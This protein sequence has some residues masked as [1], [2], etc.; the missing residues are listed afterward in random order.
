MYSTAPSRFPHQQLKNSS[1]LSRAACASLILALMP[2]NGAYANPTGGTVES[3]DII[4]NDPNGNQLVIDQNSQS[5]VI[6]WDSFDILADEWTI[7]N[8]PGASSVT[9]N[10]IMGGDA[11]QILGRLSANGIIMIVNP[12][13][14][15][16]GAGSQVDV[17][18]L[19]ATTANISTADFMAG[20]MNFN[21]AGNPNASI[22][23]QGTITA[24]QGG[25]VALVAPSVVNSGVIRANLGKVA[26]GA[27]QTFSV[28]LYGDN[29]VS[30]AIGQAATSAAAGVL[31]QG[32]LEG[33]Q[34]YLSAK[35]AGDVMTNVVNNTG[36]IEASGA[37][38]DG[39]AIVLNGGSNGNVNVAGTVSSSDGGSVSITGKNVT[40]GGSVAADG[41]VTLNASQN[42]TASGANVNSGQGDVVFNSVDVTLL[43]SMLHA[44]DELT[45]NNSGTFFSN[46]ANVLS[47]N[48]VVLNQKG[49]SIQNAINAINDDATGSSMLRLGAHT[50]N[51]QVTINNRHNFTLQGTL[52]EGGALLSVLKPANGRGSILSVLNSD[53]ITL[54]SLKIDGSSSNRPLAGVSI[55]NSSGVTLSGSN[56][57]AKGNGVEIDGSNGVF[58]E[59]N[60]ISSL[61]NG[62]ID[63]EYS[64]LREGSAG[65]A[66]ERSNAASSNIVIENNDISTG[67]AGISLRGSNST[68]NDNSIFAGTNGIVLQDA[69]S[70][71]NGNWIFSFDNGLDISGDSS[72]E[73]N[74]IEIYAGNNAVN[75]SGNSDVAVS[76]SILVGG[77][78]SVFADGFNSLTLN[79]N[80]IQGFFQGVFAING[81]DLNIQNNTIYADNGDGITGNAGSALIVN[82]LITAL[83]GAGVQLFDTYLAGIFGNTILADNGIMVFNSTGGGNE[84]GYSEVNG[85]GNIINASTTG[86]GLYGVNNAILEGN[87]IEGGEY[88][89]SVIDSSNV[90]VSGNSVTGADVTGVDVNGSS[91]VTVDYNVLDGNTVGVNVLN[92]NS[93]MLSLNQITGSLYGAMANNVGSLMTDGNVFMNNDTAF[94]ATNTANWFSNGDLFSDNINGVVLNNSSGAFIVN[95]TMLNNVTGFTLN[96]SMDA[97]VQGITVDGGDTAFVLN[98]NTSL[99]FYN[100]GDGTDYSQFS[101]LNT[102][103]T[104]QDGAGIGNPTD[105]SQQM[106][107]YVMAYDFTEEELAA[108][109]AKTHDGKDKIDAGYVFY[110]EFAG[111]ETPPPAN[112]DPTPPPSNA[113]VTPPVDNSVAGHIEHQGNGSNNTPKNPY[114][115]QGNGGS[116]QVVSLNLLSTP[117]LGE[118]SPS[119][120]GDEGGQNGSNGLAGAVG[121]SNSFLATGSVNCSFSQ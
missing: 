108:A 39:N 19:V 18:G 21:V 54:A 27:G 106:F 24:A 89:I 6:N 5:G 51:E 98:G 111:E 88:G 9:L 37:Y 8:Q 87:T 44:G 93:I 86:I 45:L 30:F 75:V 52:G 117:N 62:V 7:F 118:L 29:L 77:N 11:S 28:D 82:N 40:L 10:R 1:I 114:F 63:H 66:G 58:I 38:V 95:A 56:V 22:I 120:G 74:G 101:N 107:Q 100:G 31:N 116:Y 49:G 99:S 79:G 35:V 14:V 23:N 67:E 60:I 94:D 12:N 16:F 121:C 115:N 26:L 96:D 53:D 119:A 43:G 32:T 72:V 76:D 17:G 34:V 46:T 110:K 80:D 36:I 41:N 91:N 112:D 59:N 25:L 70:D 84:I 55:S 42:V 69:Q 73:A 97:V 47:G 113:L 78:A 90:L 20:N 3:G 83:G 33:S 85:S 13:G 57:N 68:I 48:S 92:S 104:L 105:A 65:G 81:G 15:V 71:I 103:F 102:Y 109:E 2:A 4:I 50:W 64:G 61:E